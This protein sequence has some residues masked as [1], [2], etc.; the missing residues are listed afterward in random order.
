MRRSTLKW[1]R[2]R[3][4]V[5]LGWRFALK[6]V[7]QV[8][9]LL[10]WLSATVACDPKASQ[11]VEDIARQEC[12]FAKACVPVWFN[13][14]CQL[15]DEHKQ[16]ESGACDLR[17]GRC[18]DAL[19][20]IRYQGT[21]NLSCQDRNDCGSYTC[22]RVYKDDATCREER[23]LS[24]ESKLKRCDFDAEVARECLRLNKARSCE[25]A[26]PKTCKLVFRDCK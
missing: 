18:R 13:K 3:R 8:V 5:A 6:W 24:R 12:D 20:R 4:S 10:V 9:L 7:G 17:T 14:S 2:Q 21:L 25:D 15:C 16:C 22:R 11:F 23:V 26:E 19:G 1:S